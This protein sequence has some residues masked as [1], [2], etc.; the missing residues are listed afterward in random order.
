MLMRLMREWGSLL[1]VLWAEQAL[2]ASER[3]PD[4]EA[5]DCQR[6]FAAF[7]IRRD[8]LTD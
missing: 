3:D 5:P 8:A 4:Q 1:V 2:C 7:S 6:G